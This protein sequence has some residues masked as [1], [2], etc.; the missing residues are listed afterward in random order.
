M[1]ERYSTPEMGQIWTQESRFR[2]ML[3]VE[4]QVAQVQAQHKIIPKSAA[5]SIL[6]RS[7]FNVNEIAELERKLKHDVIAFVQN[8]ASYVGREGRFLHF[9]LTSSDVLDTAF[10]LQIKKAFDLILTELNALEETY[11]NLIAQNQD[12]ICPG[13]T[14]GMWAEPTTFSIKMSGF[15]AEL[16]RNRD[17]I[18]RAQKINSVCKLS[19]AVGTYSAL[20]PKIEFEVSQR[21]GLQT[22]TVATQVIPRDRHAEALWALSMLLSG[23]ERLAV[24]LRHLQRSEVSE[25]L[26]SFDHGQKGSSAMPHKQNPISAENI[27]GIARMVRSYALGAMENIVLWHERDISHSSVERVFFPDAFILSHYAIRR[28]NQL[29]TRLVVQK[30]RMKLNVESS[31]GLLMSSHLLLLLIDKGLSREE[32]YSRVQSLS[33]EAKKSGVHLRNLI[34]KNDT[35]KEFFSKKELEELFSGKRHLK[36]QQIILNRVLK[37]K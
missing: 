15:L 11:I 25:V 32:A 34:E 3:E 8:V 29:L 31:Q 23:F 24:E 26:E 37:R 33:F 2:F 16:R 4:I 9:G 1:I 18:I 22:E 20:P 17:R 14:H 10:S 12:A 28:L 19:G 30:D 5:R 6:K 13:R 35:L 36:H 27:T 21:L 7:K